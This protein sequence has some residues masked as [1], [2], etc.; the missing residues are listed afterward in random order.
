[1]LNVH[2]GM[3]FIVSVRSLIVDLST[4]AR[5]TDTEAETRSQGPDVLVFVASKSNGV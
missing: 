5:Y 4:V 1:M 3:L 2:T